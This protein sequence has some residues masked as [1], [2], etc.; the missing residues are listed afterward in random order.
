MMATAPGGSA[1]M[2][3]FWKP[4]VVTWPY[5]P[6]KGRFPQPRLY[7]CVAESFWLYSTASILLMSNGVAAACPG[8][9]AEGRL[10]FA[11]G[12]SAAAELQ[13]GFAAAVRNKIV[14]RVK[15]GLRIGF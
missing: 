14:I 11:A 6:E 15:G 10:V 9:L 5:P 8:I 7:H 1:V 4:S 13:R 12:P 3:K 2:R